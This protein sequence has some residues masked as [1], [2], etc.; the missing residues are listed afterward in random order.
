MLEDFFSSLA[1]VG[2]TVFSIAT[3]G[4]IAYLVYTNQRRDELGEIIRDKKNEIVDIL[5]SRPMFPLFLTKREDF[6]PYMRLGLEDLIRRL[7][8]ISMGTPDPNLPTNKSERGAHA[9]IALF[10]IS[11]M[12][13][14]PTINMSVEKGWIFNPDI[15]SMSKDDYRKWTR[16][17]K[18]MSNQLEWIWTVH[19]KKLLEAVQ[20]YQDTYTDSEDLISSE[21]GHLTKIVSNFFDS[22]LQVA[23][24]IEKIY[25]TDKRTEEYFL[26]V[27]IRSP[28]RW[29][30]W[31]ASIS[32]VLMFLTGVVIPLIALMNVIP[33]RYNLTIAVWTL[34]AFIA[35][36]FIILGAVLYKLLFPEDR[37]KL[38]HKKLDKRRE[39]KNMESEE[40]EK[41]LESIEEK[42]Q[43]SQD[44]TWSVGIVNLWATLATF[45]IA[46]ILGK[47]YYTGIYRW[48]DFYLLIF[49]GI[50]LMPI[51]CFYS[52]IIDLL[53]KHKRWKGIDIHALLRRL[54]RK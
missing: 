49:L 15:K 8:S 36:C 9:L 17:F 42:I 6:F 30:G 52:D 14:I 21:E 31:V 13:P 39:V 53:I 23:K 54:L 16:D 41:R 12:Y 48:E 51:I 28:P 10:H 45:G 46:V 50:A 7:T 1:Q 29:V 27:K 34:I 20:A 19:R 24:A 37:H 38:I 3:A 32:F 11:S 5:R 26:L 43:N 44:Y 2:I 33:P 22:V 4:V 18:K 35:S 25:S 47:I 40:I